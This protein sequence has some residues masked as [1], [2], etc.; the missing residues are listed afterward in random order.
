MTVPGSRVNK[1]YDKAA[2]E[3][4]IKKRKVIVSYQKPVVQRI[5]VDALEER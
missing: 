2:H 1:K 3:L 5:V 4:L